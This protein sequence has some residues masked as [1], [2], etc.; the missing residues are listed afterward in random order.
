MGDAGSALDAAC[1]AALQHDKPLVF[2]CP[3]SAWAVSPV[4]RSLSSAAREGELATLIL[5]ADEVEAVDLT[6]ALYDAPALRP[7]HPLTG[8]ARTDRL[9]RAGTVRTLAAVPADVLDLVSR[10]TIKPERLGH[11]VVA[12]PARIAASG[13]AEQL[14][15]ILGDTGGLHRVI[16]TSDDAAV[17]EWLERHARRVPVSV[18]SRPP[19][20][21]LGPVRYAVVESYTRV[22]AVRA[23]LD[24]LNPAT[25]LLWEPGRRE[26]WAELLGVP[27]LN[28]A[29]APE[30]PLPGSVDLAVAAE[31]P[32]AEVLARLLEQ[33]TE[34]L[35]LARGYQVPYLEQLARPLKPLRLPSD[36][37]R[38]RI[39][40]A[41]WRAAIRE[42]LE[43]GGVGPQLAAIEPLL[44]E[45]DPAVIAAAALAAGEPR[46]ETAATEAWTRLFVSVGHK[47]DVRPADL[48]GALLNTV[49]LRRE[50]VGRI[51]VRE[52]HS[53]VEVRPAVAQQAVTGLTGQEIRRRRVRAQLARR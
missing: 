2:V 40:G 35:V 47:H 5:V 30:A 27:G 3:P 36:V 10:S 53:F 37:D 45:Y 8:I 31:L 14:D 22:R 25:A 18:G 49:G 28:L 20:R 15:A 52:A 51:D 1:T 50:D 12:G 21:P 34:V 32:S 16:V 9:I 6:G 48:F 46:P 29:L 13:Q 44:S 33:A 39:Q 19:A 38:A 42:R 23:A 7:M 4:L 24:I 11:L 17:A 43:Q 26:P 41:R